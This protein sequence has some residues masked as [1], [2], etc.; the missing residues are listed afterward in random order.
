MA[1][2][3]GTSGPDP[4]LAG[5]NGE[6]NDIYGDAVDPSGGGFI[7]ADD[8]LTGGKNS[9]P[10]N[11]YGDAHSFAG[12]TSTGGNDTLIG[13]ANS[14]NNLY[15]DAFSIDVGTGGNDTLIG[16]I[17]GTNNLYGDASETRG[18]FY[19]SG[20][21]RLVSAARTT[22]NM[23]G[24][25]KTHTGDVTNETFGADTFVFG[26]HNGQDV[27]NDFTG[28]Q[29][30]LPQNELDIIEISGFNKG[31]HALNS[32]SDLTILPVDTNG[33]NIVDSSRIEFDKND[34][35]TVLGYDQSDP[36]HTLVAADFMF[37]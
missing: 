25:F 28:S 17:G 29:S 6:P 32:F 23:W 2:V 33:D 31:G 20:D 34:T 15:G 37:T 22:D 4:N 11:L 26:P 19:K 14:T 24:D 36:A 16:G 9:E 12:G 27:I 30:G 10:N 35:V 1:T 13:G 5:A 18:A 3:I 21:D 7:G 8:T